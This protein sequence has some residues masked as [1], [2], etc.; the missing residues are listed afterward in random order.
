MYGHDAPVA[1]A[2]DI[3]VMELEEKDLHGHNGLVGRSGELM[4]A[5]S[6]DIGDVGAEIGHIPR[7]LLLPLV[8]GAMSFRTMCSHWI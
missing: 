1:I 8:M 5:L 3:N 2:T 7:D 4:G 6:A